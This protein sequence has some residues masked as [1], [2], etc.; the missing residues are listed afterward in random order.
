MIMMQ[1]DVAKKSTTL[2]LIADAAIATAIYNN[3]PVCIIETDEQ[4]FLVS[5]SYL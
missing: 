1:F 2:H 5:S 4:F 3:S